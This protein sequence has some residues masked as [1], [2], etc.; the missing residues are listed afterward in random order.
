VVADP[1]SALSISSTV[2]SFVVVTDATAWL[3]Y[4][5]RGDAAASAA[6]T[7]PHPELTSNANWPCSATKS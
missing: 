2:S 3:A 7:G 1:P 5:L 4:Q 6:F